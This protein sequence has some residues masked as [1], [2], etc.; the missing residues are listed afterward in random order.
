[1]VWVA[2][3]LTFIAILVVAGALVYAFD[4]DPQASTA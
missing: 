1:M 2:V 4:R 3:G